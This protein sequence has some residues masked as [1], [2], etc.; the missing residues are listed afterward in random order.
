MQATPNFNL[1]LY[2][3][4]DAANLAD[5][6]NNAMGKIDAALKA[7]DDKFPITGAEIEDGSINTIDIANGAITTN[8]LATAAVTDDKLAVGAV[9]APAIEDNAVTTSAIE[10]GAVTGEKIANSS[11]DLTK[12]TPEALEGLVPG[13]DSVTTAMLQDGSVTRPK[14]AADA[15]DEEPTE[16]SENL[17]SS[18]AVYKALGGISLETDGTPTEGSEN[19]VTS[20]GVF[21]ADQKLA[22]DISD[23]SQFGDY[24]FQEVN[25]GT[26]GTLTSGIFALGISPNKQYFIFYGAG[27]LNKQVKNK[28]LIP[29]QSTYYGVP[30]GLF[31]PDEIEVDNIRIISGAGFT[32]LNAVTTVET[33]NALY[34]D[35]IAIGTDRQ[36]YFNV[37]SSTTYGNTN[38]NKVFFYLQNIYILNSK[39]YVPIIDKGDTTFNISKPPIILSEDVYNA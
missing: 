1:P 2:E 33:I 7:T 18:G 30:T 16:D 26:A 34:I 21:A 24:A 38:W 35:A 12:L 31:F 29:G 25:L 10:D 15:F 39:G 36:L 9:T 8:K 4:D 23:N 11:I 22:Q 5:G 6:Y 3:L 14:I 20:G 28:T 17:I 27:Q 32:T 13:E 37:D 19:L